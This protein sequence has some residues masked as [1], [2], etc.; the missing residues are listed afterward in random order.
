MTIALGS[1]H[2]GSLVLL[3]GAA[4]CCSWQGCR[5]PLRGSK[6]GSSLLGHLFLVDD[7]GALERRM[8]IRIPQLEPLLLAVFSY[9]VLAPNL[10]PPSPYK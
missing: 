9:L 1:H 5:A 8:E 4:P 7:T 2:T 3:E 6:S 10:L